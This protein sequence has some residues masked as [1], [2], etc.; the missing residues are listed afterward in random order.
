[1]DRK[2]L[3]ASL[4]VWKSFFME[5]KIRLLGMSFAD[6]KD[7]RRKIKVDSSFFIIQNVEEKAR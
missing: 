6:D 2:G 7:K 3:Y 4:F 5:K 1:M